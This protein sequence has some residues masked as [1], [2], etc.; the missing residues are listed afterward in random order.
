[1]AATSPSPDVEPPT[2]AEECF[3]GK[4]AR[5]A[6]FARALGEPAL[7]RLFEGGGPASIDDSLVAAW[8]PSHD[9][10]STIMRDTSGHAHDGLA[11]NI[12]MRAVTG[13]GWS[14]EEIDFRAVPEQYDAVHFH[15]DDLEDA[16]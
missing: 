16:H 10:S 9:P 15:D 5:P 3:N 14:G 13:P 8:D 6:V 1:M 7:R 4:I 12:P 11:L 2:T